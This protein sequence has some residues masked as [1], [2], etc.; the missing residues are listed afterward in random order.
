MQ[1]DRSYQSIPR[2]RIKSPQPDAPRAPTTWR[3]RLKLLTRTGSIVLDQRL[4]I[5]F[6]VKL[7]DIVFADTGTE[8][9]W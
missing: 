4:S 8:E 6:V 3:A 7:L 1:S 9:H 5:S 2:R